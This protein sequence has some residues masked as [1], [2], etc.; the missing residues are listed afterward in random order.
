MAANEEWPE[1]DFLK[2]WKPAA[3]ATP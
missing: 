2:R 3:E 1:T